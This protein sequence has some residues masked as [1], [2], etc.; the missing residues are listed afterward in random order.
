MRHSLLLLQLVPLAPVGRVA[1]SRV[2]GGNSRRAYLTFLGKTVLESGTTARYNFELAGPPHMNV[3]VQP[4][5]EAKVEDWSFV[6]D[7][8]DDP[9]QFQPPYQVFFSYGTDD[10]PL[11]FHID[12]FVSSKE[13]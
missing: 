4:V 6:R 11:K 1:A 7:M 3:F 9:A 5:G 8:L 2:R 10:T 13:I 12:M